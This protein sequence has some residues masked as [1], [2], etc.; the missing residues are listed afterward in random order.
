MIIKSIFQNN[1][2]KMPPLGLCFFSVLKIKKQNWETSCF[3][4]HLEKE[5]PKP[6]SFSC[7][8]MKIGKNKSLIDF[9]KCQSSK[10]SVQ[11]IRS[12]EEAS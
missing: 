10:F 7:F 2:L 3:L 6:F 1:Q 5:N 4:T 9:I 8:V 11:S 12:E